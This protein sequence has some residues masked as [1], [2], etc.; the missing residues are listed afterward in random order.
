MTER[1]VLVIEPDCRRAQSWH[2]ILRRLSYQPVVVAN[3]TAIDWPKP[4]QLDWIAV[5]FGA[6]ESS[7][8]EQIAERLRSYGVVLPLVCASDEAANGAA[9]P[10]ESADDQSLPRLQLELP[11]RPPQLTSVLK[12]CEALRTASVAAR[13]LR[14]QP[15]GRSAPM[16]EIQG[17]IRQVA[18]FD[19]NVLILGESG[20]GK[21]M[22]ARHLHE[23]SERAPHSFVPVNCGAIPADLLESE[24]FGHEKGAFTGAICARK[25]RFEFADGGTIFLDE[26]G[27]MSLTMQVK[28][29]RVLQEGTFE[30]VGSNCTV[31]CDV[32]I[33]AATHRDLEALIA[34]GKF[35]EDLFY[36]LNVFPIMLPPLRDR[37]EDMSVL[38]HHLLERNAR[39][40]A[41]IELTPAAV[42]A[43]SRCR[44]PGN[45]RELSNL[46]ERLCI[47]H[48]GAKVDVGQLP[49]RY[50]PAGMAST[51][52]PPAPPTL[53]ATQPLQSDA[54]PRDGFDLRDHLSSIEVALIRQALTEAGGTVAE[55]AR[56]LKMQ[57]TT[58][59]EKLK[60]YQLSVA[61]LA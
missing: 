53:I 2:N 46:L 12:R 60:K 3:I 1:K 10:F 41:R 25:G 8:V 27:D 35:R 39:V 26:I 49:E 38:I 47:L 15:I 24:L 13:P 7:A 45:V 33:I 34:E 5:M 6:G 9:P 11:V 57:R 4:E 30:R 16:V 22:V 55:A 19:S 43:L 18:S 59:V 52:K 40:A 17:L 58:L 20:T 56:L 31:E 36:R 51:L 29:L 14:F 50:R 48:P 28:L 54:L 21:E 37:I 61:D 32:R 23:L 42:A 44:W